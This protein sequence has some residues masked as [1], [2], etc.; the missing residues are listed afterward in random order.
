MVPGE[1]RL[2]AIRIPAAAELGFHFVEMAPCIARA[3]FE[4]VAVRGTELVVVVRPES[5]GPAAEVLL[6]LVVL[7]LPGRL[8]V[9]PELVVLGER[10]VTARV[11]AIM[12]GHEAF[13]SRSVM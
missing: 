12:V 7:G 4:A 1:L 6:P 3:R 5:V 8:P 9:G 10:L 2:A 13:Q 11:F